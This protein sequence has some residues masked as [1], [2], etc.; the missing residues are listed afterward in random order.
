MAFLDIPGGFGAFHW[1]HG[2]EQTL[3]LFS[4]LCIPI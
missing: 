2:L 3:L 4:V 1:S